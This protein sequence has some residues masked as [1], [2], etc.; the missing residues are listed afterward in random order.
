MRQEFPILRILLVDFQERATPV[1]SFLE[2]HSPW[3]SDN[4]WWQV[5]RFWETEIMANI[6]CI[7]NSFQGIQTT[8]NCKQLFNQL[9]SLP[10]KVNWSMVFSAKLVT[11]PLAPAWTAKN[12]DSRK[13]G[14]RVTYFGLQAGTQHSLQKAEVKGTL[15]K[16][17]W[18]YR[19]IQKNWVVFQNG[20]TS[21]KTLFTKPIFSCFTIYL[22]KC[23]SNS[24]QL[25]SDA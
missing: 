13:L 17:Y 19:R 7:N 25:T 18:E 8:K 20:N 23:L 6:H 21:L 4:F 22:H 1:S 11:T 15:L 5:W 3:R 24:S 12:S 10:Q 14:Y 16:K 9:L 2:A